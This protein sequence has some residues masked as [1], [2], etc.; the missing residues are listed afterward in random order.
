[1][2]ADLLILGAEREDEMNEKSTNG[3][4]S[5]WVES[6]DAPQ[7]LSD[8]FAR[9]ESIA[10]DVYGRVVAVGRRIVELVRF[11]MQRFPRA[12]A[13]G[14]VGLVL[15]GAAAAVPGLGVVLAPFMALLTAAGVGIAATYDL[16]AQMEAM[17]R[18]LAGA[19]PA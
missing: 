2:N 3:S 16:A 7:W 5:A 15:I 17:F 14:A 10:V 12:T 13:A 6:L 19:Q 8:M 1:M 11:A 18:D 9:I 4:L